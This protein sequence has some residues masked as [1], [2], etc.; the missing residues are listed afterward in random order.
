VLQEGLRKASHTTNAYH[1]IFVVRRLLLV[2]AAFYFRD[3]PSMQC[4]TFLVGSMMMVTYLVA[5]NPFLDRFD[6]LMEIYNE[7]FVLLISI[8]YV[9]LTHTTFNIHHFRNMGIVFNV[10]IGL[11]FVSNMLLLLYHAVMSIKNGI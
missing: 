10:T 5:V 7:S 2:V 6:N 1:L 3:V 11:M 8:Y 4:L 9:L